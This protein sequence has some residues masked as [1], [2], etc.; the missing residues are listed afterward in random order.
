MLLKELIANLFLKWDNKLVKR[1]SNIILIGFSTTGKSRVGGVLAQQL[2][3]SLVDTDEEI[4]KLVGKPIPQIF[5]EDGE[6]HF[7][8]LERQVLAKACQ[9]E[10]TV[11][12]AGGGAILD[13]QNRE[14]IRRSGIVVCLEASVET[15]YQRL[16]KDTKTSGPLRPLLDV[17]NPLKQI[18]QLKEFRQPYYAIADWTVHTDN[19]TLAEV[20]QE[21]IRGWQYWSR[22]L[23][24]YREPEFAAEVITATERYPIY[25]GWDILRSLGRRIQ[26]QGLSGNAFIISDE[27]VSFIYGT[28]VK[29]C[30]EEAGFPTQSLAIPPGEATKTL[31]TAIKIYDWLVENRAERKDV[32]IALGGGMVGDLGG[33]VAATFLRGLNLVQAPT[34]LIAMVDASIGGKTAVNHPQAKNI[35]GAFYQPRLVLADVQTLTTLPQRE[36]FSGWS[37]VIKHGLIFDAEFFNFLEDSASQ[38]IK[39]EPE[40]VTQAIKKSVAIKAGIVSEDEKERGKRTLLNFGHTIAHGLEAATSYERF[41]HGEAVSIGMVGEAQLSQRLGLLS[42]KIVERQKAL[43]EKFHLPTTCPG[44]DINAV[45]RAM[46]LDKKIREKAIRWV[47]LKDIGSPLIHEDVPPEEVKEVLKG[48]ISKS[49]SKNSSAF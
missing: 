43:L 45:L 3:W 32:I 35:I 30:L 16:L 17:L 25:V 28:R 20:C 42:P 11:I 21:V 31:D 27:T 46:E 49:T 12:A 23:L 33:F 48:L 18:K 38:L 9:K 19:L 7:R 36:L 2:G 1:G 41:L 13:E 26:E 29:R 34:S 6:E 44:V 22:A 40:V 47:L 10:R 24:S 4:A 5:A 15:I 8:K 37:E 14:L 39:F